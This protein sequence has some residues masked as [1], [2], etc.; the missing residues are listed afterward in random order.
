MSPL[1][2][3]T[4]SYNNKISNRQLQL[5]LILDVFG[6]GV[7]ALP[8]RAAQYADQ[9]GWLVVIVAALIALAYTYVINS[10]A[11]RFPGMSFFDYTSKL[12]SR[13]LGILISLGFVIKIFVFAALELRLF[14]EIV[15]Q[16]ML[17]NT[18]PWIILVSM[19]LVSAFA[20]AKGYETR[21]RM[22]E[23]LIF[24]VLIPLIIIFCLALS[25]VDFSNLMPM[26]TTPPERIFEGGL[27]IA[28][29]FTGFEF[30]LLAYPYLARPKTA[31][32]VAAHSVIFVGVLS[33]AI[34]LLTLAKFGP[35]DIL[36]QNWPVLELMDL[37][38]IPGS[39][40]ERQDALMLSFWIVSVFAIIN[41][42][43]FFSSLLMKD[44]IKAGRHSFYI[45]L[46]V[47]VIFI[48]SLLP[49]NLAHVFQLMDAVYFIGGGLYLVVIP[50]LLLIIAKLR[51]F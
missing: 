42:S 31:R 1:K 28:L 3:E 7:L 43:L 24:V 30:C 8:R 27:N 36:V 21:A 32:K 6:T 11:R 26:F 33:L 23:V 48:L 17:V 14:C 35:L 25:D 2:K 40:I 47:P 34:V 9:D 5:L 51:R 16:T 39:F 15:N 38:T 44:V 50:V 10:L 37:I 29:A 49:R 4:L 45:L 20:A 41:A 46:A 13:P 19:L 12:I 18:P 22:G